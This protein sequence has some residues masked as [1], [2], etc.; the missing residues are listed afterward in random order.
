MVT[1]KIK[2][3][4]VPLSAIWQTNTKADVAYQH[5]SKLQIGTINRIVLKAIFKSLKS[6]YFAIQQSSYYPGPHTHMAL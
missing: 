2:G 4:S 3:R 1:P 6:F 5:I